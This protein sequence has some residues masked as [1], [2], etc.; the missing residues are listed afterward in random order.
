VE[1]PIGWRGAALGARKTHK[2][3]NQMTRIEL[4]PDLSHCV[5]TRARH[6]YAATM[7][8]ILSGDHSD[9]L[10]E[11]LE[12]LK[13]FLVTADFGRLRQESEQHMLRG[14]E[15]KFVLSRYGEHADWDVRMVVEG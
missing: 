4:L 7:S 1:L 11:R 14:A 2:V 9:A 12:L 3:E 5:E 6:E 10:E 8:R 13:A 15:V